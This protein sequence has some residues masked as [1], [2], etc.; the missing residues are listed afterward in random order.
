MQ[1]VVCHLKD[2]TKF[3]SGM[4]YLPTAPEHMYHW[5]KRRGL[6]PDNPAG[7]TPRDTDPSPGHQA[8]VP[9]RVLITD[10][11]DTR[12]LLNSEELVDQCN[13]DSGPWECR[14]W[15]FGSDFMEYALCL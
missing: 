8:R 4:K 3:L 9:I 7:F 10:R 6:V 5:Y 12:R 13:E 15:M 1:A 14:F 2:L 11:R